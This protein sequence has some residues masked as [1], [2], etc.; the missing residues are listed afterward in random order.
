VDG[1]DIPEEEQPDDT[2]GDAA[3]DADKTT[4]AQTDKPQESV[5][6]DAGDL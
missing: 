5:T 3:E 2:Q 4:E 1:G 6:H